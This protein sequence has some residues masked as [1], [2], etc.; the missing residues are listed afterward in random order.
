MG[1]FAQDRVQASNPSQSSIRSKRGVVSQFDVSELAFDLAKAPR[2]GDRFAV[3]ARAASALGLDIVNYGFFDQDAASRAAT[4]IQFMTTMSDDWMTHYHGQNLAARDPHVHRV[5]ARR[6]SPYLWNPT[7]LGRLDDAGERETAHEGG[8]AGLRSGLFVP[9]TSPL[10]PFSPVACLA[11][12]GALD[13][14]EFN[15]IIVERG[16]DLL[17]IAH[18]FHN[19]TI[20][21][22]WMERAGARPLTDREKDCL[23]YLADGLRQDAIADALGL[24]RVTVEMHL[25]SA[26]R[27][28]GARTLAE[29]VARSMLYGQLGHTAV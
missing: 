25:R 27:K 22:V 18:V 15:K 11:F 28:L 29:A 6:L 14:R 10:D 23:R 26:R 3:L 21:S 4:D 9:M 8:E 16:L 24:A 1:C 19:A 17:H 20:R 12:G 7:A 5:Q 13:E 2:P